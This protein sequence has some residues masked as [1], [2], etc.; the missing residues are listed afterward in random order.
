MST[1][2]IKFYNEPKAYGFITPDNGDKDV[3]FHVSGLN[4]KSNPEKG[5]KVSYTESNA[6]RGVIAIDIE[7][8]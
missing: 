4:E 8:I 6:V 2:T 1:G 7:L 3:F 5:Q